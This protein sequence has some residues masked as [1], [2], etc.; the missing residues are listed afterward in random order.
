MKQ[1]LVCRKCNQV[2]SVPVKIIKEGEAPVKKIKWR[3]RKAISP[4]GIVLVSE[5]P[6]LKSISGPP[7]PLEFSPQYWMRLDDVLPIVG[8]IEN[9][10]VWQGCCGPAGG[11]GP[12]RKCQCETAIGTEMNDCYTSAIFIPEKETTKWQKLKS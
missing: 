4:K 12:N 9:D 10:V 8:K 6:I 5:E 3:D 11:D 2:L 7:Q 1:E